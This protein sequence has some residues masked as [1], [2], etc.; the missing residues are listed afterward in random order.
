[1]VRIRLIGGDN[2]LRRAFR[3]RCAVGEWHSDC[4]LP[5]YL[6]REWRPCGHELH[7][8]RAA[9]AVHAELVRYEIR[10]TD[11]LVNGVSAVLQHGEWKRAAAGERRQYG[12][13]RYHGEG[14]ATYDWMRAHAGNFLVSRGVAIIPP[15]SVSSGTVADLTSADYNTRWR[16]T[17]DATVRRLGYIECDQVRDAKGADCLVF[18]GKL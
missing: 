5:G 14:Q 2:S 8:R 4:G 11:C 6:H 1:M 18:G 3:D 10:L 12:L 9:H 17:G 13:S 7:E 16:S 15:V